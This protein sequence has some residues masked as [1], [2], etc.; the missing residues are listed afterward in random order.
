[1][2]RKV[3]KSL[4]F[5][6]HNQFGKLCILI[7][8][9]NHLNFVVGTEEI[10]IFFYLKNLKLKRIFFT[11]WDNKVPAEKSIGLR[12]YSLN[13]VM[14]MQAV[15]VYGFCF[16]LIYNQLSAF[17]I[18]FLFSV[19]FFRRKFNVSKIVHMQSQT[20]QCTMCM[21]VLREC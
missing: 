11:V 9:R 2:Q 18:F 10:L 6:G 3:Q 4:R 16:P 21:R 19:I 13:A 7:L 17:N 14:L 8:I 1:M 20:V 15:C 5:N 12:Q